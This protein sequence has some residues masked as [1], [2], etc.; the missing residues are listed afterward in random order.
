MHRISKLPRL[1][2]ATYT[3]ESET[4]TEDKKEQADDDDTVKY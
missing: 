4:T 2:D 1:E 3:V